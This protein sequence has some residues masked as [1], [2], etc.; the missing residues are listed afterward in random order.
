MTRIYV[1][2]SFDLYQADG[3]ARNGEM[4]ADVRTLMET[5][6]P[7]MFDNVDVTIFDSSEV[8]MLKN[9]EVVIHTGR[10]EYGYV[11]HTES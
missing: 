3:L 1:V 9:G 4:V 5:T 11:K 8:H 6:L 2:A 7:Y 10:D